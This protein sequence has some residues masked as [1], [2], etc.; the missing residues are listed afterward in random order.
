[1]ESVN[2]LYDNLNSTMVKLVHI[3]DSRLSKLEHCQQLREFEEE[4]T[5]VSICL[6]WAKP[7]CMN[8]PCTDFTI[9]NVLFFLRYII[10][11]MIIILDFFLKMLNVH[12]SKED[13]I[14]YIFSAL[15]FSL[16]DF[17]S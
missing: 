16:K 14:I 11:F 4:C 8:Q 17:Y 13:T 9:F 1:M 12:S 3:A 6:D 2:K 10:K 5:K 15:F 7:T